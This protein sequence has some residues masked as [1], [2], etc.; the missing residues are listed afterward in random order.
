MAKCIPEEL[1]NNLEQGVEA[2]H[3][4]NRAKIEENIIIP[5]D[6]TI[7]K[8]LRKIGDYTPFHRELTM[9]EWNAMYGDKNK[10][11]AKADLITLIMQDNPQLLDYMVEH[12]QND[13]ARPSIKM[14]EDA[15]E[16]DEVT[17]KLMPILENFP[18]AKLNK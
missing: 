12:I 5:K 16:M 15:F 18:L 6:S 14:P 10:R 3:A 17:G 4:D 7:I 11:K 2:E 9:D 8:F 1:R 13:I